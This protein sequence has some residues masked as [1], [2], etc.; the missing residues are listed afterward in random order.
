[1]NDSTNS[2]TLIGKRVSRNGG[3]NNKSAIL[4]YM[5]KKEI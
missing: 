1:M 5:E 4:D 2:L 3:Y